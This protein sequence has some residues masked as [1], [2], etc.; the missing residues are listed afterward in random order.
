ML[1]WLFYV[2]EG[3]D[4]ECVKCLVKTR[5]RQ[6]HSNLMF[7]SR[8][9]KLRTVFVYAKHIIYFYFCNTRDQIVSPCSFEFVNERSSIPSLT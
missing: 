2:T 6:L 8:A 7:I 4:Y 5:S 9:K 3:F 1:I